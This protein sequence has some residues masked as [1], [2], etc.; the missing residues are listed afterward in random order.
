MEERTLEGGLEPF[1]IF[2]H[3]VDPFPIQLAGSFYDAV[4]LGLRINVVSADCTSDPTSKDEAR[5]NLDCPQS[6][7]PD[8]NRRLAVDGVRRD[9]L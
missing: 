2:V 6:V 3:V 4:G 1:D 7:V 9:H 5:T 8:I